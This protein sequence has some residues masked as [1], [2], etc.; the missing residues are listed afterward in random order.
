MSEK[1]M[2]EGEMSYTRPDWPS[3][4]LAAHDHQHCW[5]SQTS[6]RQIHV[7]GSK[8]T[9][10]YRHRVKLP[11][12]GGSLTSSLAKPVCCKYIHQ[13]A[14]KTPSVQYK[15][16]PAGLLCQYLFWP[17]HFPY[18]WGFPSD[19]V[20]HNLALAQASRYQFGNSIY[21]AVSTRLIRVT[22]E[23]MTKLHRASQCLRVR[24]ADVQYCADFQR[25]G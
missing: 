18:S 14:P 13:M 10:G 21:P 7:S 1:N 11:L 3:S 22:R 8:R 17:I 20:Y 16:L 15:H 2:T 5:T 24:C 23:P 9:E 6:A 12:Y 4:A 19:P 25:Q